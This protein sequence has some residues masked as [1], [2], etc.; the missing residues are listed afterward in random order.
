MRNGDRSVDGG[1]PRVYW[2]G[3]DPERPEDL[4]VALRDGI[5][6]VPEEARSRIAEVR[7]GDSILFFH[8]DHG[9]ILCEVISDAYT[10]HIPV[11][12]DRD[13]PHR[14]RL[15]DPVESD[16]YAHL[17]Q[18]HDCFREDGEPVPSAA[19]AESILTGREEDLR[20]LSEEEVSCLF[21]RLGWSRPSWLPP[22]PPEEAPS[23][24]EP[25]SGEETGEGEAADR[26][27]AKV[28]DDV[29]PAPEPAEE[30]PEATEPVESRATE[31]SPTEEPEEVTAPEE[32]PAREVPAGR[33]P[34][35]EGE[36]QP[37]SEEVAGE[38][39]EAPAAPD[40]A[41]EVTPVAD[42]AAEEADREA[43][44][45][46]RPEEK[47]PEEEEAGE[48]RPRETGG[49]PEE[50]AAEVEP[51]EPP[52]P[53][54]EAPSV[55]A[56]PVTRDAGPRIVLAPATGNRRS[57]RRFL[58][59]MTTGVSLDRLRDPLS[60]EQLAVLREAM[61]GEEAHVWGVAPAQDRANQAQ[62]ASV[63]PGDRVLFTGGGRVFASA[64][65]L[66]TRR[67]PELGFELWG[68]RDE[69]SSWEFLFF[70]T[71]PSGQDIAYG[72][73]NAVAG[74]EENYR[75]PRLNLLDRSQS[76]AVLDAFPGLMD[77]GGRVSPVPGSEDE[78]AP[79]SVEQI[80]TAAEE[81][82]EPAAPETGPAGGEVREEAPERAADVDVRRL[83]RLLFARREVG[84]CALCGELLPVELLSLVFVKPLEHCTAEE[85]EDLENDVMPACRMGCAGLFEE[86]YLAVDAEGRVRRGGGGPL[87]G[88]LEAYLD[89]V[90]GN[91]CEYW[92]PG[93]EPFF[94]WHA[95]RARGSG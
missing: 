95:E 80:P 30:R 26:P 73:L 29:E 57:R 1:H 20:P 13:Y 70:L 5:W 8:R 87:T 94:R 82:T 56:G 23:T 66:F 42:R 84:R 4:D 60:A 88:P 74:Y 54:P 25:P 75:I 71:P 62:W 72:D 89:G 38:A 24:E 35:A 86:G 53:E 90:E 68:R 14:V 18:I 12:P 59:T 51:P 44:R 9:L 10:E 16:R 50:P 21:R 33:D 81:G 37:P 76:D 3:V 32:P 28:G 45:E 15:S 55:S 79:A 31:A 7:E 2:V 27:G 41:P 58:E 69:G 93:S 61:P 83:R 92:H 34:S 85:L 64:R 67:D 22:L 48:G 46:E 91:R 40:P 78:V 52:A 39:D 63:A 17:G 36:Q 49:T 47:P 19:R 77:E 11:W 65:V 6:G 43:D